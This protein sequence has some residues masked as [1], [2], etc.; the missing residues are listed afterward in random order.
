MHKIFHLLFHRKIYL[1]LFFL[2]VFGYVF[3]LNSEKIWYI[4]QIVFY[5]DKPFLVEHLSYPGGISEY[6]TQFFGQFLVLT[7]LGP[8][9]IFILIFAIWWF[10]YQIYV[11]LNSSLWSS[12]LSLV[13]PFFILYF[14]KDPQ[15]PILYIT[16]LLF[17]LIFTYAF[18]F[19]INKYQKTE[20]NSKLGKIY[21]KKTIFSIQFL[22]LL[23]LLAYI[24]GGRAFII[25]VLATILISIRKRFNFIGLQIIL[26][27]LV[28]LSWL[29][30]FNNYIFS[31]DQSHFFLGR[32]ILQFDYQESALIYLLFFFIPFS[33]LF[34]VMLKP[35]QSNQTSSF[36][37]YIQLL[38]VIVS[39]ILVTILPVKSENIVT[40]EFRY[41]SY[42]RKWEE[43]L[44]KAKEY[45]S[46]DRIVNFYTNKALYFTGQLSV[47]LF[48]Y[49]QTWGEYGLFLTTYTEP[50]TLLDN[51][52]LFYELGHIGA[53][54]YWAFEAQ[55]V[56]ENNPRV[57]LRLIQ[58]SLILNQPSIA[59]P[60]I[61]KLKNS[62]MHNKIARYYEKLANDSTL[63]ARDVELSTKQRQ[64]PKYDFF[65]QKKAA[66]K[67]LVDLLKTD[68][69]NRMAYEYLQ[70]YY[71]LRN[72]I[73]LF[74]KNL[75]RLKHFQINF[76]PKVYDE[77][78]MAYLFSVKSNSDSIQGF[79]V[80]DDTKYR[81]TSY[82]KTI[83]YF[84]GNIDL[85]RPTLEELYKNTYW[86]YLHFV[87]P[88]TLKKEIQVENE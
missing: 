20:N 56:Y 34:L 71:L 70:T 73:P 27:I 63:V 35:N 31:V 86:F 68:S 41:L 24:C 88:V 44:H 87:S 83:G 50:T 61:A 7:V 8:I 16:Q 32:H 60:F 19:L 33:A 37:I 55:T 36:A 67:E 28:L 3:Y 30:Y 76:L 1:L 58:T 10:L 59:N 82:A 57:L 49:P 43:I 6:V 12:I 65:L 46:N 25:F 40:N 84:Q 39:G 51:C 77:A 9:V 29:L 21:L 17:V 38:V 80:S 72:E 75:Y 69:T 78:T 79:R 5:V 26:S 42:K 66:G 18:Y 53:A 45:R 54:R 47:N 4:Q 11:R 52:D 23:F 48:D 2:F 15:F 62:I 85:A 22:L 81:F 14:L 74:V 64:F 13:I